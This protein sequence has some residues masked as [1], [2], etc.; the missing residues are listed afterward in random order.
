[1]KT[2]DEVYIKSEG[3]GAERYTV[4]FGKHANKDFIGLYEGKKFIEWAY[5]NELKPLAPNERLVSELPKIAKMTGCYVRVDDSK[6]I[7]IFDG[8]N[9]YYL[10][11]NEYYLPLKCPNC[12]DY[13]R[14]WGPDGEVVE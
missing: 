10:P 6:N 2:G 9:E 4:K 8:V 1:M 7:I 3:E 14:Q 12:E 5:L 13:T 11:T